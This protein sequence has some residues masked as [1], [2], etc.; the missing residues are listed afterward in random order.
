[1]NFGVFLAAFTRLYHV[2]KACTL[3]RHFCL[4]FCRV[5]D[6]LDNVNFHIIKTTNAILSYPRRTFLPTTPNASDKM[7]LG[8][9]GKKT[10]RF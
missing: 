5:S 7:L 2:V 9:G 10:R 1:M 6:I 8:K 3:S 4:F